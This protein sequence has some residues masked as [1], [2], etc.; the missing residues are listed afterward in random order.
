MPRELGDVLHLF[1]PELASSD[2]VGAAPACVGAPIAS[3][4]CTSIALLR[5]LAVETSRQ[6]ARV[7]LLAPPSLDGGRTS[8]LELLGVA[9]PPVDDEPGVL[10]CGAERALREAPRF[11]PAFVFAALPSAWLRKASD[12]APLLRWTLTLVR[13]DEVSL[14]H[15]A[16][17]LDAIATT[18]PGARLGVTVYGVRTLAEARDCFEHL[19][20][21]SEQRLGRTLTSYGVLVDDVRLSRSIVTGRPI[22]LA[23]P[24]SGAARALADVAS[25]L[26]ADAGALRRG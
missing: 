16:F 19:A 9:T 23:S 17:A 14:T 25:L 3:A 20:L 8:P 11:E 21:R 13:P 10:V 1:A 12:L 26:L 2:E 15:A 6:G 7:S 18:A 5:N 24:H 4:D 22:A